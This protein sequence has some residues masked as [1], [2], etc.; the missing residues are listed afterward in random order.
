MDHHVLEAR[1]RHA[2]R[3]A[4]CQLTGGEEPE[5]ISWDWELPKDP[6]FGDLSSAVAF[7]LASRLRQ[8]PQ[9]VADALASRLMACCREAGVATGME[10]AEAKAGFLNVWLSQQGLE[11]ILRTILKARGRFGTRQCRPAS[12]MNPVTTASRPCP[13]GTPHHASPPPPSREGFRGNGVNIEFVSANPTG[14]LSV[15]HG[16]Q[17]AVGDVLSRLLR[18]QGF[19]VTTEYYLNDE[20]RQIELLGQ[21]LRARYLQALGR[22]EPVPEEGYQ[23]GYVVDSAGT[24]RQRGG[25]RFVLRSRGWFIRTAMREQLRRIK[26][27]LARFGVRFD[28]WSSQRWLRTSGRIKAALDTL[29]SRGALYESDGALWFASTRYG[30]DKDRVVRKQDGELT[31]LAPDIAYHQWKCERGYD[32]V[33]NL[34][35]PDHHG[36]IARVKAA[37]SALGLPAE[38]LTVRIVQLVTLSRAGKPV[39]MSKRQGEFVTFREVLDEVGVDATRFFFLMRTMESP[40]EFDLELATRHS[41]ENPVYYVQYAHAR[42]C[43]ILMNAKRQRPY[44]FRCAKFIQGRMGRRGEGARQGTT[45][46]SPWRNEGDFSPK[47]DD[48]I[49][50]LSRRGILWWKPRRRAELSWLQAPE[51]RLLIRRLFQYPVV[52]RLCAE[53][54][55]PHSLTGYLQKLAET[56]HVFYTKHRVITEDVKRSAARL[57]LVEA[58]QVV[59]ANGLGLLGIRAP[60]RM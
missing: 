43:G 55:E 59:L 2:L 42:I 12:S 33:L 40:L 44:K 23:G 28:V 15:A 31:Y 19:R 35:G 54:L 36:Y 5:G 16:R 50:R 38:R 1:L 34:W 22:E 21:S 52:L 46:V 7:K 4:V 39:P 49:P 10:R 56:F 20:G 47:A 48:K 6:A 24:L 60:S 57:A 27:D 30:D 51:E 11:D 26:D 25:D 53:A 45:G 58:T 18:S 17:A 9:Q 29:Q 14:P 32:R 37:L 8:S 3:Q 13:G 41:Q